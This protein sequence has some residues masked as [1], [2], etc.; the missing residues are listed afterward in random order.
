MIKR[1]CES[2][3]K[4]K[5]FRTYSRSHR[6][7]TTTHTEEIKNE[8]NTVTIR[9]TKVHRYGNRRSIPYIC[10]PC[11]TKKNP[12]MKKIHPKRNKKKSSQ[13]VQK[14]KKEKKN[15]NQPTAD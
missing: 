9:Q 14:Q 5:Q 3:G 2:C 11:R 13:P 7:S 4:I 6:H 1:A 15:A 8:D 12:P 10:L